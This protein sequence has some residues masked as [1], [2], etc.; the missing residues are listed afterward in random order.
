MDDY[1]TADNV[2]CWQG[3]PSSVGNSAY[4]ESSPGSFWEVLS[5]AIGD[6]SEIRLHC[7]SEVLARHKL[8]TAQG[9]S[10]SRRQGQKQG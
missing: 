2:R 10:T 7:V 4:M 6:R 8:P 1:N 3:G 5:Q 9:P